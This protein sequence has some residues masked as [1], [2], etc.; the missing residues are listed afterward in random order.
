MAVCVCILVS[1]VMYCPAALQ[2][3]LPQDRLC[4][5]GGFSQ[6]EVVA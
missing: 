6:L 2:W 1:V 3:I 5:S 4:N